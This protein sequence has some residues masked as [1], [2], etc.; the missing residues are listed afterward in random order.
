VV[1]CT[2][3]GMVKDNEPQ[4]VTSDGYLKVSEIKEYLTG[5]NFHH[6][7]LILDACYIGVNVTNHKTIVSK[8]LKNRQIDR[9]L[10][11]L[12]IS[13]RGLVVLASSTALQASMEFIE[14]GHGAFTFH[15]LQALRGD[16]LRPIG[17]GTVSVQIVYEHV[18]SKLKAYFLNKEGCNF[19][20]Q[21]PTL[22]SQHSGVVVLTNVIERK[23]PENAK[24]LT[25]DCYWKSDKEIISLS[26]GELKQRGG[27][28][29]IYPKP[30]TSVKGIYFQN[31]LCIEDIGV[32]FGESYPTNSKLFPIDFRQRDY[33]E[34]LDV[35]ISLNGFIRDFQIHTKYSPV[36][37]CTSEDAGLWQALESEVVV[38]A[39]EFVLNT[40]NGKIIPHSQKTAR[41]FIEKNQPLWK[42]FGNAA[43]SA[44]VSSLAQQLDPDTI[45]IMAKDFAE[46]TLASISEHN[47][48]AWVSFPAKEGFEIAGVFGE[49]A[50]WETPFW[51]G[52]EQLLKISQRNP[53]HKGLCALGVLYRELE[54]F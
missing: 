2:S 22:E 37:K 52:K 6:Q 17:E 9:T 10:L 4:I 31:G 48:G 36:P 39:G 12:Q 1:Y 28:F 53:D 43:W 54:S 11:S 35:F 45:N 16:C 3:H 8:K 20:Q 42:Q 25:S 47:K 49:T 51:Y 27:F 15:L 38:S 7:V 44:T 18:S 41:K 29:E 50:K 34:S 23:P 33:I 13:E 19:E 40:L 46:R 32:D 21:T 14:R 5:S 30:E 24:I 26:Y